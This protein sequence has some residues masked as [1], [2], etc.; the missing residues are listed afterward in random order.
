MQIE[1]FSGFS[2][3][4]NSTKRPAAA[5]TAVNILVKDGADIKTVCDMFSQSMTKK[6]ELINDEVVGE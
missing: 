2:K 3:R 5:G 6:I 1:I 4:H